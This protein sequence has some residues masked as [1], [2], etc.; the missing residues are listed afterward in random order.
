MTKLW[1]KMM[2]VAVCDYNNDLWPD[3]VVSNDL[4]PD[5]LFKNNG[6]GTFNEVAVEAGIAYGKV[7][8][9]NV[10]ARSGMGID[11]TD[12]DHSNRE[13]LAITN[14]E[15]EMIGLYQNQGHGLFM[16]V[17]VPAGV[18]YA[19]EPYIGFGCLFSDVDNDGWPDLAVSNGHVYNHSEASTRK[20]SAKQPLLLFRNQGKKSNGG[21]VAWR[22]FR[23]ASRDSGE[24]FQKKLVG[25]GLAHADI[26]LDGD[27]D[28]LVCEN[29]GPALLLRND[30][31]NKNH[32]IR[33]VLRGTKSNRDAIGAI[34][35]GEVGKDTI[36]RRVNGSS[37]YLSQSELPVTLGLGKSEQANVVVRWPSG[38]LMQLGR[39]AANHVLI[40]HE[41]KGIV[42]RRPLAR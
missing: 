12:I 37:S 36:R 38:K 4:M 35:W 23:D 24:G 26:D 27:P 34:V 11:V 21:R 2:G 18:A 20:I 29:S 7:S 1:G 25:R 3:I 31:A 32:A 13:S 40:V 8:S 19:T 39:V 10:R 16:D 5:H 6:N 33:V 14:F 22:G 42:S 9:G 30:G 15:T 17:A 28:L 41:D